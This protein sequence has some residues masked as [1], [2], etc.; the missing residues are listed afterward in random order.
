[1][2]VTITLS[3]EIAGDILRQITD[4]FTKRPPAIAETPKVDPY[5]QAIDFMNKFVDEMQVGETLHVVSFAAVKGI[6]NNAVSNSMQRFKK[7]GIVKMVQ[8][9]TWRKVATPVALAT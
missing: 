5:T 9:G 3:D 2:P 7:M 8:K 4:G 6:P 1:M